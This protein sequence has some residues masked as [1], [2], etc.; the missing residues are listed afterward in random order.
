MQ[1]HNR[2]RQRWSRPSVASGSA[3]G[4]GSCLACSLLSMSAPSTWCA[5]NPL[6]LANCTLPS[7]RKAFAS[8]TMSLCMILVHGLKS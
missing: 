4:C 5:C 7:L 6:V 3:W 2:G 8:I 1:M